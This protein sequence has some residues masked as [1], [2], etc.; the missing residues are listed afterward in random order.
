MRSTIAGF[1]S[2]TILS[3]AALAGLSLF[4]MQTGTTGPGAQTQS[5]AAPAQ[6][7]ASAPQAAAP[8]VPSGLTADPVPDDAQAALPRFEAA[9]GPVEVAQLP[10]PAQAGTEPQV[11]RDARLTSEPEPAVVDLALDAPQV[12]GTVL[13]GD[14]SRSRDGVASSDAPAGLSVPDGPEP[15]LAVAQAPSPVPDAAETAG[16][17]GLAE[18]I[19]SGSPP[20]TLQD[21]GAE[22]LSATGSGTI[23][24]LAQDVTTNRLPSIGDSA[25][26]DDSQASPDATEAQEALVEDDRPPIERHAADFENADN[27][28]LMSI[29][30][31]DDSTDETGPDT[32]TDFPYP[33]SFAIDVTRAD[34]AELAARYRAAGH[35][36]LAMTNLPVGATAQDTEV[37]MEVYLKAVPQAVAV[38]EGMDG[39]L[40][41]N[42]EASEQLGAI[43]YDSGHG[44]VMLPN[45]LNTAQKL[46]SRQG[47]PAATVFRDFD[48]A[49]QDSRAIR[50]F[51]DQAAFKAGQGEDGVIMLGRLRAETISA[52]TVWALQ[53]RASSVTLSPVSAV[54]RARVVSDSPEDS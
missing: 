41:S 16:R 13:P 11:E 14:L 7:T 28:P 47:V 42:R 53:D 50:R 35:E 6:A 20:L 5:A 44:L 21:G 32:V 30:L 25:E 40:Q 29:V 36:V 52:L 27:K 45:G 3:G 4:D 33:V 24:D 26:P 48:G 10:E 18:D 31:I 51:L 23:G 34:A 46:I 49:G 37:A 38:F 39:G 19:G 17:S 2:G 8:D 43:L 1:L 9:E 54:L 12:S 22:P 15:G